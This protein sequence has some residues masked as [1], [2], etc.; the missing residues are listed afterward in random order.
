MQ[1]CKGVGVSSS[2]EKL[3]EVG[4]WRITIEEHATRF[5]QASIGVYQSESAQGLSHQFLTTSKRRKHGCSAGLQS[6]L[7]STHPARGRGGVRLV[8]LLFLCCLDPACVRLMLRSWQV[9]PSF[10]NPILFSALL[11]AGTWLVEREDWA[12]V[13]QQ[14]DGIQTADPKACPLERQKQSLLAAKSSASTSYWPLIRLR[15]IL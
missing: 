11:V 8:R 9:Q 7:W 12:E 10:I 13:R 1:I 2:L 3:T 14:I 15:W 5:L 4:R 6:A